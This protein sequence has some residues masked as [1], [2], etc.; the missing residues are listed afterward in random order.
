MRNRRRPET[1]R[2]VSRNE[3][4]CGG[5]LSVGETDALFGCVSCRVRG[6]SPKVR[7]GSI[8]VEPLESY[9]TPSPTAGFR[10]LRMPGPSPA[11]LGPEAAPAPVVVA[12]PLGHRAFLQAISKKLLPFEHSRQPDEFWC[13]IRHVI[14]RWLVV[15]FF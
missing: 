10:R 6:R 15:R 4:R 12:A 14:S 1:Q 8:W 9:S 3:K 11:E 7:T 2:R 5:I 13:S